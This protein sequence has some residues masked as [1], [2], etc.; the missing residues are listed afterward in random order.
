MANH[1]HFEKLPVWQEAARL[2]I[3]ALD[4]LEEPGG[5]STEENPERLT[6]WDEVPSFLPGSEVRL[7]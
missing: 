3:L 7:L 5:G 1:Q 2:Y 4:L 6:S